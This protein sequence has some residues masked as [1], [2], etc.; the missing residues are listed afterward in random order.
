MTIRSSS[1]GTTSYRGP[2]T[3]GWHRFGFSRSRRRSAGDVVC[4][5]GNHEEWLLRTL[6]DFRRHSWLMGMEAFDTIRSYSPEGAEALRRAHRGGR[7]VA[8]PH[9]AVV[10]LSSVLRECP[11]EPHLVLRGS[12]AVIYQGPDGIC[13]HGG[14]DISGASLEHQ[15]LNVFLGGADGFPEDYGGAAT[16]V[17]G[18]WDNA[19]LDET[20]GGPDRR[21][22]VPR[23]AWTQSH[24]AC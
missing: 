14:L 12:C 4:L 23:L 22:L 19:E 10:A 16:V 21:S 13:V 18:H 9:R 6:D 17:Y 11:E 2:D 7:A 5:R 1:W 3:K 8:V 24:T 20:H 15:P